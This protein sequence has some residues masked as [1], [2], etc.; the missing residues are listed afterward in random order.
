MSRPGSPFKEILVEPSGMQHGLEDVLILLERVHETI[1]E[2]PPTNQ[3]VYIAAPPATQQTPAPPPADPANPARSR[4][5]GRRAP[6]PTS[7]SQIYKSVGDAQNHKFGAGGPGSKPPDF[8]NLAPGAPPQGSGAGGRGPGVRGVRDAAPPRGRG[9]GAGGGRDIGGRGRGARLGPALGS[10][11]GPA[12]GGFGGGRG[13]GA[14]GERLRRGA[15]AGGRGPGNSGPGSTPSTPGVRAGAGADRRLQ[16][17]AD[18]RSESS[19][20]PSAPKQMAPPPS[21]TPKQAAPPSGPA[22]E[23]GGRSGAAPS[24]G[25]GG[26]PRE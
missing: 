25:P 20:E 1:P 9:P 15:G 2:T 7:C 3:P 12:A 23:Q 14:G 17:I 16:R 19:A 10:G 26:A 6:K 8:K 5:R 18:R 4:P 21:S 22:P 11:R 24:K 13:P